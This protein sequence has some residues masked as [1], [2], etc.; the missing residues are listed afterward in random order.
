M[1]S[2]YA[3]Y[4]FPWLNGE[5]IGYEMRKR[6]TNSSKDYLQTDAKDFDY[7]CVIDLGDDWYTTKIQILK[8]LFQQQFSYTFTNAYSLIENNVKTNRIGIYIKNKEDA[9]LIKLKWNMLKL[10]TR[11]DS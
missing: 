10:N 7:C 9:V 3:E 6:M 8:W 2:V 4:I 5:E 1:S 11:E